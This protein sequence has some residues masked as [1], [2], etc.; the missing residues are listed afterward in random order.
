MCIISNPHRFVFIHIPKTAGG[1]VRQAL[2]RTANG[3]KPSGIYQHASATTIRDL[4]K[5]RFNKYFSFTI[6]RNPWARMWSIYKFN[7]ERKGKGHMDVGNSFEDFLMN[8]KRT[9][10]WAKT[11]INP[12]T[13]LQRRPQ[14]DWI[15][16]EDGKCIVDYIG[17]FETLK[18]SLK[19]ICSKINIPVPPLVKTHKTSD[20]IP[21]TRAYSQKGIDFIANHFKTDIEQFGYDFNE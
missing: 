12:N 21:Y 7:L 8:K 6:V 14:T 1:S 13:P 19:E 5:N 4:D 18:K 17:K 16:D 11:F 9:H 2:M 10:N 15:L 3:K 20:N